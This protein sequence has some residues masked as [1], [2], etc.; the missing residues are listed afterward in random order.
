M[1]IMTQNKWKL[2]LPTSSGWGKTGDL[3]ISTE[4][5][6]EA[7]VQIVEKSKCLERMNQDELEAGDEDLLVCTG[8][9]EVGPCKVEKKLRND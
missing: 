4:T 6:Q 3:A 8:G 1:V 2:T 7:E 9:T 5:L